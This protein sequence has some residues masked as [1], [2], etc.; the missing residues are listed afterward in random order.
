MAGSTLGAQLIVRETVAIETLARLA[1]SCRV[2]RTRR[3]LRFAGTITETLRD[4]LSIAK[5][6]RDHKF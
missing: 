5:Q 6:I 3:S 2:I 1:I 4:N